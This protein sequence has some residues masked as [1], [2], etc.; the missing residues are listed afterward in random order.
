MVIWGWS[1]VFTGIGTGSDRGIIVHVA[2]DGSVYVAGRRN[3]GTD[4]DVLIL[5]Y[6]NAGSLIWQQSFDGGSGDD[7][8]KD[9]MIDVDGNFVVGASSESSPGSLIYDFQVS[10]FSSDGELLWNTAYDGNGNDEVRAIDLDGAG[11][12]YVTGLSDELDGVDV[13]YKPPNPKID[14]PRT[15][16]LVQF[17]R[18]TV[19]NGRS[20]R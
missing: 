4:N 9:A 15:D 3:N 11:N 2:Q 20:C 10:K 8:C 17:I 5:K 1:N 18:G 16:N 6:D 19:G 12:I 14:G 7:D 13:N